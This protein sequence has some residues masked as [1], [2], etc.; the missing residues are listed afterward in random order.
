[1]RI[2]WLFFVAITVHGVSNIHSKWAEKDLIF[3]EKTIKENHPG[4][5]NHLD[6]NFKMHLSD[7]VKKAKKELKKALNDIERMEVLCAFGKSFNDSHLSVFFPDLY[8]LRQ[9]SPVK[10]CNDFVNKELSKNAYFIKIPTFNPNVEDQ[11]KM[12]ALLNLLPTLRRYP[13]IVFDVRQN[14]GGN[15]IWGS[16]IANMLFGEQ[17]AEK[18]RMEF[19]KNQY[20]DYRASK[21]N[22]KHVEMIYET[23]IIPQSGPESDES[24]EW[25]NII[26]ELHKAYKAKKPYASLS[27]Y[28]NKNGDD[29]E[30]SESLYKG[31][32]IVL[33]DERCVSATLDFIDEL[34]LLSDHVV[35]IGQTTKSDSVYME[36]RSVPLPSG[37]GEFHFPIKVYRNR[38]RGHNV[39]YTPDIQL[40]DSEIEQYLLKI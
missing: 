19:F 17:Y 6:Q 27:D 24:I 32:I 28:L 9:P 36:L 3:I 38:P 7:S 34:K 40:N 10:K 22:I 31:K 2:A 11:I 8:Q 1:M 23:I 21:D 30:L 29:V 15:S 12:N 13:L 26:K 25:A 14:G 20:T 33:I 39:P 4:I 5:H 35:L 16:R 37:K 18:K